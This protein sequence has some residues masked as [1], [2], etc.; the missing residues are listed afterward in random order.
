MQICQIYA[1]H[2]M[3]VFSNI[4]DS[5]FQQL[6]VQYPVNISTNQVICLNLTVV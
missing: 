3:S 2:M 1:L 4:I 5:N 6:I